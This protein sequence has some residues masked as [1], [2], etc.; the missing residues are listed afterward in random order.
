MGINDIIK[1]GTQIKTLRKAIGISQKDFAKKLNIPIS[2]YSNYE[3]NNR[4]PDSETLIKIATALNVS[5]YYLIAHSHPGIVDHEDFFKTY[6]DKLEPLE[7]FI[8][9]LISMNI[10]ISPPYGI[11][12]ETNDKMVEALKD[13]YF[14]EIDNKMY[15][16]TFN[17]LLNFKEVV[18]KYVKFVI[19][20]YLEPLD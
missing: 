9:S 8:S 6:I 18:E 11:E 12:S 20:D 2:T 14:V 10:I 3:N 17:E 4:E 13:I 19:Q 16:I 15:T 7:N 1:I 5:P